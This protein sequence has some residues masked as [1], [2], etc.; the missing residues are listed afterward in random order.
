[1]EFCQ[2]LTVTMRKAGKLPAGF[3]FTLPTEAQW[4]YACRAGTVGEYAGDVNALAWYGGSA[5]AAGS[6][7]FGA[8]PTASSKAGS[9]PCPVGRKK[10]NPWDF[11]DMHGNT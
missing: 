7:F 9:G 10:P 8:D 2:R 3:A 5:Q 11:Y 1:M 4:E 6:L